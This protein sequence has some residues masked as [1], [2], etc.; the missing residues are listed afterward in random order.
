MPRN[1]PRRSLYARKDVLSRICVAHPFVSYGSSEDP[2][3]TSAHS[4]LD[5]RD[6]S[7]RDTTMKRLL[8]RGA[9]MVDIVIVMSALS[10]VGIVGYST[11]SNPISPELNRTNIDR[12]NPS[13]VTSPD[14]E[15]SNSYEDSSSTSVLRSQNTATI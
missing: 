12:S 1:A 3:F 7:D 11:F 6:N 2:N 14:E 5:T 15:R 4:F 10:V 13:D 8:R 9:S